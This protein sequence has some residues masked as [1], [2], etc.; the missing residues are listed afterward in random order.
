[1]TSRGSLFLDRPQAPAPAW[2]KALTSIGLFAIFSLVCWS[3][4]S[5]SSRSLQILQ[6]YREVFIRGW[7]LT[8]A[9]SAAALCLSIAI[10]LLAALAKK[11]HII[12]IRYLSISYIEI[13]RGMPF[14]VLILIL[15]FGI[16]PITQFGNR[17]FFGVLALSLFSGAYLAEMIRAGVESVGAS[18]LES[19]RAIGLTGFQTYRYV[20]F[21]QALRHTLPALTGQFA[22]LI[23]DSSLLSVIGLSEFTF[24]AQQVFNATYSTMESFLPLGVGYL[25]LTVPVSFWTKSLEKRLRYET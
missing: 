17:M 8:V 24:S 2:A 6:E 3:I 23:K 5:S 18:Q 11:S 21:P 14:L 19:A 9:I 16:V 20:I 12:V 13:V 4:L 7:L 10:G 15:W 1:M 22:S 25:I